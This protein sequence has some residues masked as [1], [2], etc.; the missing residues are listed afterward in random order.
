[1]I[2]EITISLYEKSH[3]YDDAFFDRKSRYSINI[4]IINIFHNRQ[5]I[6][7]ASE[8]NDNRHDSHCFEK[9]HFYKH[10]DFLLTSNE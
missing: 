5:I 6:D 4:Q 3:F 9:T 7:Y 1:M 8:F 2:D 10:H